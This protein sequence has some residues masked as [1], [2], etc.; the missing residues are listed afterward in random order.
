RA[1]EIDPW[2]EEGLGALKDKHRVIGDVRGVGAFYTIELVKDRDTKEPL[3]PWYGGDN[4][5]I[6]KLTGALRNEGVYAFGRYNVL[7]VTPPLTIKRDELQV[8]LDGLDRA[9]K[10]LA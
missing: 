3:V 7:L 1:R 10:V 2:L 9:L 4:A 8:G 5:P 6:G